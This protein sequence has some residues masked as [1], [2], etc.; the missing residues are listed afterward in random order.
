VTGVTEAVE[1]GRHTLM[2]TVRLSDGATLDVSISPDPISL[3]GKYVLDHAPTEIPVK[4]VAD[5]SKN[6]DGSAPKI[7]DWHNVSVNVSFKQAIP[8]GISKE[9]LG[10]QAGTQ[11][12]MSLTKSSSLLENE[13]YE[14]AVGLPAAAHE[15]LST[16]LKATVDSNFANKVGDLKL[17]FDTDVTLTSSHPVND[18]D[19]LLPAVENSF[20]NFLVLADLEDISRMPPLSIATVEGNAHLSFSVEFDMP[21]DPNPLASLPT[22]IL[23]SGIKVS[24]T[25][26]L[27]V[28][29][30]PSIVGGYR[31]QITKVDEHNF[32]LGYSKKKGAKLEVTFTGSIGISAGFGDVDLVQALLNAVIPDTKLPEN[33]LKNL[34]ISSDEISAMATAIKDGIQKSLQLS[35]QE[36]LDA[37]TERGTAFLYRIDRTAL[38]S[39][40]LDAVNKAIDGDLS[41]IEAKGKLAGVIPIRSIITDTRERSRALKVNLFGILNFVTIHDYI[42][43]AE[44]KQDYQTGDVTLIDTTSASEV[45]YNIHNLAKT[46][47]LRSLLADGVLATCAY[48]ASKTGYQPTITADC[49]AFDLQQ[50]PGPGWMKFCLDVAV[51]LRLLDASAAQQK[52]TQMHPPFGETIFNVEIR[53]GDVLFDSLFFDQDE[54]ARS[55]A[56]YQTIGRQASLRI[57]PPDLQPEILKARQDALGDEG[58]WKQMPQKGDFQDVEAI[59]R[60]RLG[61]VWGFDAIAKLIYSDYIIIDWWARAMSNVAKPL[62]AIR[63]FLKSQLVTDPGNNNLNKL[64]GNLNKQ[65]TAT[66]REVHDQFAEPWGVVAMDLASGQKAEASFLIESS[67]LKLRLQRTKSA[68]AAGAT[69]S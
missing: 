29:L 41:L 35:L 50:R 27:G 59:L 14:K 6:P 28:K 13:L 51:A 68:D 17:G 42:Q 10:I 58:L 39:A 54:V 60:D 19:P 52:L 38:D 49:W 43:K 32:L 23:G 63:A 25:A 15:Y 37:L 44:W 66:I 33:D 45:G 30:T 8:L 24:E 47:R 7:K 31:V 62:A 55:F 5:L 18:S 57:P 65:L 26:K 9:E 16:S 4:V 53:I 61:N 56:S 21:I 11:G 20:K 64:R 36:Q 67:A 2:A 22:G 1:K 69:G 3:F 40:S 46:Q 34:K 12:A 48:R